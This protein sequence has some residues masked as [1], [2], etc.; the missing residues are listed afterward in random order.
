MREGGP[1]ARVF[2][3]RASPALLCVPQECGFDDTPPLGRIILIPALAARSVQ[4]R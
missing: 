2:A 1:F 4:S 3:S